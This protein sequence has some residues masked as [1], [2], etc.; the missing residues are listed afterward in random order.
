M[1]VR[2]CMTTNPV[3]ARSEVRL[4]ETLE[5]MKAYNLRH[6]P[7]IEGDG[8]FVGI[9]KRGDVEA[10]LAEAGGRSADRGILG[11]VELGTPIMRSDESTEHAWTLLS[12]SPGLNPLPVIQDGRL[13]GTVS[14]HELL[15]ALA[16]LPRQDG[17]PAPE[18]VPLLRDWASRS[19]PGTL[20]SSF[21]GA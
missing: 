19:A 16:G 2:D 7:V 8:R 9:V 10:T 20:G 3:T 18:P 13:V 5:L 12:R 14:Q 15:R 1:N 21:S 6:L 17:E 4:S 11:V